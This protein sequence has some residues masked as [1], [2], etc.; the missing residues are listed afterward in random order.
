MA[1]QVTPS[2]RTCLVAHQVPPSCTVHK[3]KMTAM[4]GY[5]RP[6]VQQRGL[7]PLPPVTCMHVVGMW[8][9]CSSRL[10][11]A[12]HRP[13]TH[14]PHEHVLK[15]S[16]LRHALHGA[17]GTQWRSVL[18][19]L[20][21]PGVSGPLL[22]LLRPP[23]LAW[24]DLDA[25]PLL[26]MLTVCLALDRAWC[27]RTVLHCSLRPGNSHPRLLPCLLLP[28]LLLWPQLLRLALLGPR[29]LLLPCLLL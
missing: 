13:H 21:S 8:Q 19:E 4:C 3:P 29:C 28:C 17:R 27:M 20:C 7:P 11:T 1:H 25:T 10:I 22:L 12:V 5:R 26:R 15:G 14:L 24:L 16:W 23:T 6:A 2:S 18:L 9:A